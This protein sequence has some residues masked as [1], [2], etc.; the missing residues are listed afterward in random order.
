[1]NILMLNTPGTRG[2][3]GGCDQ[4]LAVKSRKNARK[5]TF[6]RKKKNYKKKCI[7]LLVMPKYW[8][9]NY[10]AHGSFPEVGQKQKMEKQK[11]RKRRKQAGF[12]VPH[13]SLTI[14]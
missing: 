1:M 13:S 12:A 8:V 11:K 10:F 5:S 14:G 2:G 6:F 3:P 4:T 9:K 7:Y